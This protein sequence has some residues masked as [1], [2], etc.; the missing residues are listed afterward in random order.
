MRTRARKPLHT[1]AICL[2]VVLVFPAGLEAVR[3]PGSSPRHASDAVVSRSLPKGAPSFAV[4]ARRSVIELMG[5]G[6]HSPVQWK[7]AT[8]LW[9]GH[10]KANWWESALAVFT[11]VRY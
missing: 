10:I 7:Y 1:A 2:A 5:T 11:L 8:G 4:A 6:D 3:D 9:G